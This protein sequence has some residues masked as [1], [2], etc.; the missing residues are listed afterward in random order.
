MVIIQL[1][2]PTKKIVFKD[3]QEITSIFNSTDKLGN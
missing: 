1:L 2:H 3:Q